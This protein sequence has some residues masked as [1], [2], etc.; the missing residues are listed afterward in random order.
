MTRTFSLIA[1]MDKKRTIGLNGTMPWHLPAD[2]GLFQKADVG[3]TGRH[4]AKN[5]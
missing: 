3:K 2:L 4:G 1:A 5:V